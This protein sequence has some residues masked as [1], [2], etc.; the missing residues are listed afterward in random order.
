M[1][2]K[3][4]I[5]YVSIVIFIL[6]FILIFFLNVNTPFVADDFNNMFVEGNVRITKI[7]QIISNQIYRYYN[8]NGRVISH[9]IGGIILMYD[10]KNINIINSIGFCILLYI[11]YSY[12]DL[13]E[14]YGRIKHK[15]QNNIIDEKK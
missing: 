14:S 4:D 7:S 2:K 15:K 10:K 9:T 6:I 5:N 11:I 3:R 8:T 13:N 1:E 12:T